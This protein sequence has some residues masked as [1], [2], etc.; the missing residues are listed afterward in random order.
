MIA[1]IRV[2]LE[3]ARVEVAN[4]ISAQ[5][6]SVIT[7]A[8]NATGLMRIDEIAERYQKKG[9]GKTMSDIF[10]IWVARR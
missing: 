5:K 7:I 8:T 2:L 3:D 1:N 10:R 4:K 9:I 6:D